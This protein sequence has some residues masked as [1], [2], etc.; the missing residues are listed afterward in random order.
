M[1][2]AAL[3]LLGAGST[4]GL[5]G[6]KRSSPF[7][8]LFATRGIS[9]VKAQYLPTPPAKKVALADGLPLIA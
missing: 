3:F 1:K 7:R 9:N 6:L 4:I 8:R 5:L 2:Q